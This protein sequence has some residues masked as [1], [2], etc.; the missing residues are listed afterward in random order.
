MEK[1]SRQQLEFELYELM[2]EKEDSESLLVRI[3]EFTKSMSDDEFSGYVYRTTNI[4]L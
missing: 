4:E 1:K 2:S 3:Q